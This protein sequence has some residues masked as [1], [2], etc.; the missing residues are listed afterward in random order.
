MYGGYKNDDDLYAN[1]QS[2]LL[3]QQ[4]VQ[5]R[6]YDTA[7]AETEEA[8]AREKRKEVEEVEVGI[9]E[10]AECQQTLA[11]LVKESGEK[12]EN[13]DNVMGDAAAKTT[14]GIYQLQ[15]ANNNA[16]AARKRMCCGVIL[17]LL[18]VA[19]IVIIVFVTKK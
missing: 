4:G 2:A 18:I 13:A 1:D 6:R 9:R 19:V 3:G 8:I 15:Q 10:I 7:G 12:L 16:K 11:D 5:V 14:E 17:L